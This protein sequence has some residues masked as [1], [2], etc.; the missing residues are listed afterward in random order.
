MVRKPN[1]MK[2]AAIRVDLNVTVAALVVVVAL[3]LENILAQFRFCELSII[4]HALVVV[5]YRQSSQ[6]CT[7]TY[8][9]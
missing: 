7:Y 4:T 2:K 8:V 9:Q 5:V 3:I 1:P 6:F